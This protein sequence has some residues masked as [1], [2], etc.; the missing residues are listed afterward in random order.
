MQEVKIYLSDEGFGPISG[1]KAIYDALAAILF[2]L[3]G[4][5]KILST[6]ILW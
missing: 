1:Q 2:S 3:T 5:V 4:I 6:T